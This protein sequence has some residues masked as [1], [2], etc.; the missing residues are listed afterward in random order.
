ME[1]HKLGNATA[2]FKLSSL[3]AAEAYDKWN[4]RENTRSSRVTTIKCLLLEVFNEPSLIF[5]LIL[6]S[7]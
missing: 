4:A 2:Q 6:D 3:Q 7:F 5:P 1:Y